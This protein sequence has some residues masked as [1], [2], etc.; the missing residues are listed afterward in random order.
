VGDMFH[1]DSVRAPEVRR[2][3]A[4]FRFFYKILPLL[5]VSAVRRILRHKL[6]RVFHVLPSALAILLEIVVAVKN[7]DYRYWLYLRHYAHQ[8]RL[9]LLGPSS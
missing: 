3:R 4:N 2:A 9:K 1:T 6:Y 7:R 8:F 5:P